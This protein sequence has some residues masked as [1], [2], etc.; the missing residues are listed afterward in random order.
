MTLDQAL[1]HYKSKITDQHV[2]VQ[3]VLEMGYLRKIAKSVLTESL[4]LFFMF[5]DCV[6]VLFF[7][8]LLKALNCITHAACNVGAWSDPS[9]SCLTA[10]CNFHF[11]NI[12]NNI[13]CRA[14]QNKCEH[15]K[16][17]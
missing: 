14:M 12:Y 5:Y 7:S 13:M 1:S 15:T 10:C 3:K 2:N 11:T 17:E 6:K 4:P 9:E 8:L 16:R